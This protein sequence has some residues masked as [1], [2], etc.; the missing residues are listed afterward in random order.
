MNPTVHA[1][2]AALP[3]NFLA[4]PTIFNPTYQKRFDTQKQTLEPT[5]LGCEL[6][7]RPFGEK[8]HASAGYWPTNEAFEPAPE[9]P[10]QTK[11]G[12]D[13]IP[14]KNAQYTP[15][16]LGSLVRLNVDDE[17]MRERV[18][19]QSGSVELGECAYVPANDPDSEWRT[20]VIGPFNSTGGFDFWVWSWYDLLGFEE[21]GQPSMKVTGLELHNVAN[22]TADGVCDFLPTPYLHEHHTVINKRGTTMAPTAATIPCIMLGIGCHGLLRMSFIEA[23]GGLDFNAARE[24]TCYHLSDPLTVSSIV[25]DNRAAN[26]PPMVWW[27]AFSLRVNKRNRCAI[28]GMDYDLPAISYF[29]GVMVPDAPDKFGAMVVPFAEPTM[30]YYVYRLPWAGTLVPF[31]GVET[32]NRFPFRNSN[33]FRQYVHHHG[34]NHRRSMVFGATPAE[35]G[36]PA[37]TQTPMPLRLI[38]DAAGLERRLEQ[39]FQPCVQ[40]DHYSSGAADDEWFDA[41]EPEY[42]A[43][44]RE[45]LLVCKPWHFEGGQ[46]LTH[47]AFFSAVSEDPSGNVHQHISWHAHYYADDGLTHANQ[48]V[49]SDTLD[50]TDPILSRLDAMKASPSRGALPS[51]ASCCPARWCS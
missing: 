48:L 46:P 37:L 47:L 49:G 43:V 29:N 12:L 36:L 10:T 40:I 30:Y 5:L 39:L 15:G 34:H 25:N 45:M 27:Y 8:K 18:P 3:N 4:R 20:S 2:L 17:Q 19:S 42:K 24:D 41:L 31:P 23:G 26:S 14:E 1:E 13:L 44:T 6:Q 35:L 11:P 28:P 9:L 7:W 51:S 32:S 33:H 21:W 38:D 50:Q 22:C 16:P